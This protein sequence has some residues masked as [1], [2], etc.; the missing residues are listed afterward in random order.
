MTNC[1]HC[2]AG[3]LCECNKQN[4][5]CSKHNT[6]ND[7]IEYVNHPKHYLKDSGHEV[8]DVIDAWELDFKLGNAVKY[9]ARAG[10]K[11]K[12]KSIEDLNKAVWYINNFIEKLKEEK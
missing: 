11:D 7:H 6:R 4:H 10:K 12:H 1:T 9:I 2:S 5:K 8:I 3:I